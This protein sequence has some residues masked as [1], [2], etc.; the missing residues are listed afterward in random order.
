MLLL[1]SIDDAE[2]GVVDQE[3]TYPVEDTLQF[4]CPT[5]SHNTTQL[6]SSKPAPVKLKKPRPVPRV[7][8]EY[9]VEIALR[10]KHLAP[11]HKR[12]LVTKVI[13]VYKTTKER[14]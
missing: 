10:L 12:Y 6:L 14:K 13:N 4:V 3:R 2:K 5:P 11:S 9:P 7:T 8:L 1:S